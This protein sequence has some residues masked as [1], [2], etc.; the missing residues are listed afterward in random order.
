MIKIDGLRRE[1]NESDDEF[2]SR[3]KKKIKTEVNDIYIFRQAVDARKKSDVHFVCSVVLS[4]AFQSR[5]LQSEK[6]AKEY[7]EEVFEYPSLNKKASARPVVIGSGPAGTFAALCLANAGAMPIIIERGPDVEER[8]KLVSGFWSGGRLNVNGNVQF[9]EGGAGTFSDGKLNT[10]TH[11]PYIRKILNEYVRFGAP[12]N[13]LRDAK[14]HIGTDIL[15]KIAINIRHE[16]ERLGGKYLFNTAVTDFRIKNGK[17]ISVYAN[18]WIDVTHVILAVGHSARDTFENL[19]SKN[20]QMIQKPFSVGVRIEHHQDFI[21]KSQYGNFANHPALKTADYKFAD[22]C[23]TFCMCPGG[24]VVA[25][26]SEEKSVVTNGMSYSDRD[27]ENA[28]SALLVN[29]GE[30]DFGSGVFDGM[31]FQKNIEKLAYEYTGSYAAPAQKLGDFISDVKTTLFDGIKPT[32]APRTEYANINRILPDRIC[33]ALKNGIMNIDKKMNG[34]AL[35]SAVLTAPETRSSSPVR[36]VRDNISCE[37]FG[38]SGL[39]PCGEGAGY[40]GGIMSAA[41]DGIRC[42]VKAIESMNK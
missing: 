3:I 13:I 5:I 35:S 7:S 30:K 1:L 21:N 23:Y 14:P 37:A 11:S 29:V 41:A 2:I 33:D 39:Y 12:D 38:V 10:G 9:G 18:E 42:A 24:Y 27:G 4:S 32:Y 34:F 22:S 20:V 16:V 36:I 25:A 6:N 17:I 19:Y 28:N 31:N 40:A 26:A 15:K 8:S